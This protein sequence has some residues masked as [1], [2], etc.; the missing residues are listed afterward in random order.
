V[1]T[2]IVS[3]RRGAWLDQQRKELGLAGRILRDQTAK[4]YVLVGEAGSQPLGDR[5]REALA[6]LR[7]LASK[8][9][10]R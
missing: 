6:S 2:P 5:W 10:R 7:A 3:T 8:T 1:S 4:Q 9:P